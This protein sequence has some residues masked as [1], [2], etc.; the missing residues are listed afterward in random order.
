MF[1]QLGPVLYLLSIKK[2]L[3]ILDIFADHDLMINKPIHISGS[4]IDH[5]SGQYQEKFD[6]RIFH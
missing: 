6:E 3:D 1:S 2:L 5:R 4:L